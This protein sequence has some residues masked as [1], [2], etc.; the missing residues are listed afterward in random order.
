MLQTVP[1][2]DDPDGDLPRGVHLPGGQYHRHWYSPGQ[3]AT[4]NLKLTAIGFLLFE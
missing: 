1:E 4:T 2:H 3:P